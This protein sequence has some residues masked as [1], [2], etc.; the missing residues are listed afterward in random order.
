MGKHNRTDGRF[1]LDGLP[2]EFFPDIKDIAKLPVALICVGLLFLFAYFFGFTELPITRGRH[3]WMPTWWASIPF[4]LISPVAFLALY[5]RVIVDSSGIS[6]R[7]MYKNFDHPWSSIGAARAILVAHSKYLYA[8]IQITPKK[9]L[10]KNAREH[11][12]RE[13]SIEVDNTN[14]EALAESSA[15]TISL[16]AMVGT[17]SETLMSLTK[18]LQAAKAKYGRDMDD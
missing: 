12:S 7:S 14:S 11:A 17:E 6:V 15:T 1:H 13:G 18:L 8:A 2:L 10:I 3:V 16:A 5:A 4:F 9:T